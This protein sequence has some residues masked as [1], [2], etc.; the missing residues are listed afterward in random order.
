M[1]ANQTN[2][3]V[4]AHKL[5]EYTDSSE[6]LV[7]FFQQIP[8]F[9]NVPIKD[10]Q[11]I[12]PKTMVLNFK[13]GDPVFLE[14]EINNNVFFILN[15]SVEL[16][17]FETST[18]QI[19]R[20]AILDTG[21]YFA[22]FAILTNAPKSA[23]CYATSQTNL[24]KLSG[25]DFLE[26]LQ[27][28][29]QLLRN[30]LGKLANTAYEFTAT[31]SYLTY[32]KPA[33]IQY[34]EEILS[35]LPIQTWKRNQLLPLALHSNTLSVAIINPS[36]Q[37]AISQ[38]KLKKPKLQIDTYLIG[39]SEYEIVFERLSYMYKNKINLPQTP[40][41][42][43]EPDEQD[44][45]NNCIL[46]S[47]L[48]PTVVN[49]K[50][51]PLLEKE[52]FSKDQFIYQEEDSPEFV[53]ILMEG[54]IEICK[55]QKNNNFNKV[56][57]LQSSDCFGLIEVL[58]GKNYITY[59]R[60]M[61]EGYV[62]KL[63]KK[64]LSS[65]IKSPQVS[66]PTAKL[67]ANYLQSSNRNIG[68]SYRKE[69]EPPQFH[70]L[71]QVIPL[72]ILM[73]NKIL[74]LDLQQNELLIGLVNPNDTS[75]FQ[76]V[77]RYLG[78]LRLRFQIISES[79]FD[80]HL[81][82][83]KEQFYPRS[84]NQNPRRTISPVEI[85]DDIIVEAITSRASDV[86]FEPFNQFLCIR[87]RIDGVLQ[88]KDESFMMAKGGKEMINRLKVLSNMDITNNMT[89]QDG[90]LR[91]KIHGVP[92]YARVSS[93]PTKFGEKIVLR[94]I[95]EA[96]SIIP[97]STIAPDKNIVQKLQ[98]IIQSKQGLFIVTGPTGSG[99]STSLYSLL[100]EI[101]K[102]GVN[103]TTLEDPVELSIPGVTQIEVNNEQ[104]M[105]F[106]KGMK[107]ILRQDPDCI[108]IG[109]IRDRE[110]AKIVFEAAVTGHLVFSTL[111]TNSSYD[112]LSRLKD[113]G[114]DY[115]TMAA[116]LIGVMAQR[117]IRK[118]CSGC[119]T[120]YEISDEEYDFLQL[121]LGEKAQ[122]FRK[123][124]KGSGCNQCNFTGYLGRIPVFEVWNKSANS[125]RAIEQQSSSSE[126]LTTL[127]EDG[128]VTILEFGIKMA[129]SGLS[130]VKEVK[131]CLYQG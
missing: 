86:H 130:T 45:L 97:L 95:A 44:I 5:D 10:I 111:H 54:E 30:L 43:D 89:P 24:L 58:C 17:K 93:V 47:G 18:K 102:V 28:I 107:A 20:L 96:N 70:N 13:K 112:V 106:A 87:M 49:N 29:P 85:L 60:T 33:L 48:S 19:N 103:I 75:I 94:V 53:Y 99:K 16:T 84:L 72:S 12:I 15:G 40:G 91:T 117:L 26:C 124:K 51:K 50:I 71:K 57:G 79:Y 104:N 128:F 22:E 42:N 14:N 101:N 56:M 90:Q 52:T 55:K 37:E 115:S 100:N 11:S 116:G 110:S 68:L 2:R 66:V 7:D 131:R 88:E 65:I 121:N 105:S 83:L 98:S 125:V 120:E 46:F 67:L 74:P 77:S 39:Q 34:N 4:M 27:S 73:R 92:V 114:V 64:V 127:K 32:Y 62:Y 41:E 63:N 36:K 122:Y 38:I 78:S 6:N 80:K 1:V 23:S 69:N 119:L 129:I 126:L 3:V 76:N 109:E 108:M 59:A 9:K 8:L 25:S 21:A 123:L 81:T 31:Q 113:F 82:S 61:G 118:N 35:F